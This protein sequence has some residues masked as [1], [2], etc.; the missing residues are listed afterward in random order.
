M[1]RI[2][3]SLF[4]FLSFG[5]AAQNEPTNSNGIVNR[6]PVNETPQFEVGEFEIELSAGHYTFGVDLP[7]GT[8]TLKRI[9]GLGAVSSSNLVSGGLMQIMGPGNDGISIDEFKNA[10]FHKGVTLTITSTLV[11]RITSERATFDVTP[12]IPQGTEIVLSSGHFE[13]GIDFE[14]GIYDIVH[15]SGMGTVFSSYLLNEGVHEIFG[16]GSDGLTI[17]RFKN[18]RLDIGTT[19]SISGVEVKL[20]PSK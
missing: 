1:K 13:S 4:L 17:S 10:R 3:L 16:Q 9:R 11:V 2:I 12:R 18:V 6:P 5:C 8:F 14:P 19:L 20:V 7:Y 15:V